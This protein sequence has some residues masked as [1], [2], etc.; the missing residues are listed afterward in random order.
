M[1]NFHTIKLKAK[2]LYDP[3]TGR[4]QTEI[5]CSP[6]E[7]LFSKARAIDFH[8]GDSAEVLLTD[9]T[10]FL[11]LYKKSKWICCPFDPGK[12]LGENPR[13]VD[14]VVLYGP[15]NMFEEALNDLISKRNYISS[16]N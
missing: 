14:L 10:R 7:I 3:E 15:Y 13:S 6:V 2:E 4:P 16:V 12:T 11:I 9:G 8:E 1:I 5:F